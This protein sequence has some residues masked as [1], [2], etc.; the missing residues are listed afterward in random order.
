MPSYQKIN[1]HDH[2]LK[3][4]DLYVGSTRSRTVEEFV[5]SQDYKI[6]KKPLKISPAMIRIF[7]EPLSNAIDNAARSRSSKHNPTKIKINI[8]KE[9]GMTQV[10]NDGDYIPIEMH[11]TEKVYNHTLIFGNLLTSSNYDDSKDRYDISGRNGLGVKLTSIFSREFTVKGLDPHNKKTFKQT[12]GENMKVASKPVVRATKSEKPYTE[13]TWYPDFSQF[14]MSGYTDDI[15]SLF[16]KYAIDTAM[17]TKLK[18]YFNNELIPVKSLV[19]YSQLYLSS[20]TNE[21]LNIKTKDCDVVITTSENEDDTQTISFASG[22]HT[23]DGGTHVDAWCEAIFRPIVQKFNKGKKPQVNIKDVRQFF[24]VFVVATVKNPEFESQNKHRL[25]SPSVTTC[26]NKKHLS[27]LFK[28]SVMDRIEDI[29]RAKELIVLKKTE[30]KR[31]GFTKI[32]GLDPA[33]NAGGL[34][35]SDCTLILCEGLS[36]K[37][38]AVTGIDVGVFGK[39]G[40]D[41]FGIYPL[42][43]KLLNTRNAKPASIAKNKVISDLIKALGVKHGVDYRKDNNF[44]TLRYG[45]IMILTDQDVDGLHISGLIQNFVHSLFPTLL[46]RSEPYIVSMQTLIAR[47]MKK[48]G[49]LLFYDEDAYRRYVSAFKEKY[50]D[51]KIKKKYYKGLGTNSNK[52]IKDT[53]GQKMISIVDDKNSL[54][55]MTK[56]FHNKH[57]D[58]RKEWLANYDPSSIGLGWKTKCREHISLTISDF[59]D[60]ELIKFSIDDCKRSIPNVL[61]GLKEGHRKIMYSVFLRNLKYT[62]KTLKVAQL[63][64]YV[65]EHSGYHHGEQ[66]LYD[67]I[68]KMAHDFP[69]SNNIPLLFRDGQFGTRLSNGKDAA[70]ARYIFTKM[71]ALTRLIFRPEDDILLDRIEDDGDVVEPHFYIPILPMVLV[72]GVTAAIGT[73]WSCSIPCYNPLDIVKSIKEWLDMDGM[74]FVEDENGDGDI[75]TLPELKPWYRGYTGDIKDDPS[76]HRYVSWGRVISEGSKRVVDELPIGMSTDSFKEKV[77]DLLESKMVKGMKNYSTANQVKFVLTESPNGIKCN[78]NTLKLYDYIHTSNMVLFTEEGKIRKFNNINE[79]LDHFC[80]TRLEY[81]K[82]RKQHILKDLRFQI[83]FMGNK[84]RFLQEVM[85]GK[86]KL[87]DG[88]VAREEKDIVADLVT[89]KYDKKKGT[90]DDEG[91]ETNGYNYLLRMQIRSFTKDNLNKLTSD[92]DSLIKKEDRVKRTSEKQMWLNDLDEFVMEYKKWLKFVDKTKRKK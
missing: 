87:Y 82:K 43:G 89:R 91:T 40:R 29:I 1:Q 62:G 58:A 22:V 51:K 25:E 64:G 84:K 14:K 19:D 55:S 6:K 30:R 18:V 79:I 75:C 24:R 78:E 32:D 2:I 20:P 28:W 61:D 46:Q 49:D 83:T 31:K 73:G 12:W 72:N 34:H 5:A 92:L 67:T 71:D 13:V 38:Y 63:S 88:R 48:G 35:S 21:I 27:T 74:V 3:R 86:L 52:D 33:N 45:K 4:P 69:G 7:V 60:K 54:N 47:V 85:T 76:N 56:V 16:R 23:S 15:I 59:I 57:A 11:Q 44:K 68:T 65:A 8:D 41:W 39:K 42:R 37:T 36:A 17:L 50:P 9:T 66:I 53:F 77:E 81:Y 90:A 10:W 26:V 80:H 70:N